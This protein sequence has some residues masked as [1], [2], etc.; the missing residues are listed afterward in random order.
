M[1]MP[2]AD[3]A[4]TALHELAAGRRAVQAEGRRGLPLLLASGSTLVLLDYATKDFVTDRRARLLASGLCWAATLGIALLENRANPVQPVGVDPAGTGP[5]A[6][7]PMAAAV[8]GWA[9]A[10]RLVVAGLRRSRLRH[11]NTAA[12]LVLAV[13]RPLGYLGVLRL[14]PRPPEHG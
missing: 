8:L 3:E 4:A 7:A 13:G 2:T 5:R 9:V 14:V 1:T 11:P 6:A 12:G 10:E